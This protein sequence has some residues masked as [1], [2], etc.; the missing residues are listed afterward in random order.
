MRN[1]NLSSELGY[2]ARK[3]QKNAENYRKRSGKSAKNVQKWNFLEK[4]A[5]KDFKNGGFYIPK[6]YK[7]DP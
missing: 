5:M 4:T 7:T 3:I 1:S 2:R 6:I